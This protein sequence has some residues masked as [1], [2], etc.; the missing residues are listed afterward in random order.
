MDLPQPD[1]DFKL[2]YFISLMEDATDFCFE[3]AKACH[4]VVLTT[5]EI[6]KL[7]WQETEKLD[8]L[9][10]THAQKHLNIPKNNTQN[11]SKPESSN[12]SNQKGIICKYF[13]DDHCT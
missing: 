5:M 7:S 6:G 1:R 12:S 9:R 3:S 11:F 4:A 10:R 13:T 8:R 2:E